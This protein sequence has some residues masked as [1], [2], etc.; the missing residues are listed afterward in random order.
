MREQHQ[1]E[2]EER[3]R[4]R[5]TDNVNELVQHAETAEQ[6]YHCRALLARLF[7]RVKTSK[8]S[9]KMRGLKVE[10]RATRGRGGS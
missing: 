3:R 7:E 6:L 5:R 9:R 8:A 10:G 4:K 2:T 1:R